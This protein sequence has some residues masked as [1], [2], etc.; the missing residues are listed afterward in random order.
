[1]S[2]NFSVSI[3]SDKAP[4]LFEYDEFPMALRDFLNA[5]ETGEAA[6]LSYSS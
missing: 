6:T 5:V 3:E 4:L 1:M 2:S